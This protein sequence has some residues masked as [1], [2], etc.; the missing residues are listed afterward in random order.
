MHIFN[1]EQSKASYIAD[2][3]LYAITIT[4]LGT[5]LLF[6]TSWSWRIDVWALVGIGLAAWTLI[7]YLLHRWVLHQLPLFRTMHAQHHARPQA[8][9][10]T[11]TMISATLIGSLI[12]FPAYLLLEPLRAAGL[13]LGVLIGYLGYALMHHAL[14]HWSMGAGWLRRRKY[15]HAIHH[16]KHTS[17]VCYGVT[18]GFWDGVFRSSWVRHRTDVGGRVRRP[19]RSD[20]NGSDQHHN[21]RTPNDYLSHKAV[22]ESRQ[23]QSDPLDRIGS[24]RH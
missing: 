8:L 20:P 14:H 22:A 21:R 10:C 3:V 18:N 5:Y 13:T 4:L 11:P 1:V 19:C 6:E 23:S 16:G 24:S 17:K 9:I 7:E 2:F 12:W 15:W